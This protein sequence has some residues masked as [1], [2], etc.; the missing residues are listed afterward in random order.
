MS[1]IRFWLLIVLGAV[2]VV[3]GCSSA[4]KRDDMAKLN[5]L[6]EA[7]TGS[8][9]RW[10]TS[11][12]T[13][14]EIRKEIGQL[15]AREL[16][17]DDAV[18]LALLNNPGL[19]AE[20]DKL[21]A[22]VADVWQAGLL[23]NPTLVL[24]P[25]FSTK[26]GNPTIESGIDL[27]LLDYFM[28]SARK[29]IAEAE[30]LEVQH[31]AAQAIQNLAFETRTAYFNLQTALHKY[32]VEK[33]NFETAE[34]SVV[35][36]RRLAEAGNISDLELSVEEANFSEIRVALQKAESEA[37]LMRENLNRL[38]GLWGADTTWKIPEAVPAIPERD[39]GFEGL[40]AKALANRSDILSLRAGLDFYREQIGAAKS[41]RWVPQLD[42]GIDAAFEE[43]AYKIGPHLQYEIPIFDRGDARIEKFVNLYRM[44]LRELENLAIH[45]RADV[46]TARDKMI[47]ARQRVFFYHKQILPQRARATELMQVQY[48][49]MLAGIFHLIAARQNELRAEKEY[50]DAHRDYYTARAELERAAGVRMYSPHPPTPSPLSGEGVKKE[51]K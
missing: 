7:R 3:A 46:R 32:R 34:D 11:E 30:A 14:A 25:R 45:V 10:R 18:K 43:D 17:V 26:S 48:N 49:A 6:A 4:P 42:T 5:T 16:T 1:T 28:R 12:A 51:T 20:F 33:L 23:K 15:L 37:H 35:M 9:V 36:H 24:S 31:H 41:V 22:A 2:L 29:R 19:Q 50:L 47:A 21:G 44:R 38:L 8:G 27:N 39:G 40:E 13:D